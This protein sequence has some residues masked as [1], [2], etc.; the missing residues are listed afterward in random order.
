MDGF[1][2]ILGY[3]VLSPKQWRAIEEAIQFKD[4]K[5]KESGKQINSLK[6][7]LHK[8]LTLKSA[9]RQMLDEGEA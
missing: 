6:I 8:L 2:T 7:Q 4:E 1:R 5:I 9:L 3:K